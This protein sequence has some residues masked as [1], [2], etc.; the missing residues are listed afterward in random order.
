MVIGRAAT[1]GSKVRRRMYARVAS[2]LTNL[3]LR[4]KETVDRLNFTVDLIEYSRTSMTSAKDKA[5]YVWTEINKTDEDVA[6]ELTEGTAL[7]SQ[8]R[9][10]SNATIERKAIATARDLTHKLRGLMNSL[11]VPADK[12]PT[13]L[14]SQLERAQTL[15]QSLVESI[16]SDITKEQ[17]LPRYAIANLRNYATLLLQTTSW[18]ADW[19]RQVP[20]VCWF[21]PDAA[22]AAVSEMETEPSSQEPESSRTQPPASDDLARQDEGDKPDDDAMHED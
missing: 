3:Q 13:I 11:G 10:F 5:Q 19:A 4:T 14:Q 6:R 22:A 15:A 8:P 7:S 16:P 18:M 1:I 12:L 21:M 2:K 9:V 20:I 17:G